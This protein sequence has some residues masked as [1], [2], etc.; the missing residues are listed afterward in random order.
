M[1]LDY[2][3]LKR[4]S[5]DIC[6]LNKQLSDTCQAINKE[7]ANIAN[8][9]DLLRSD[10]MQSSRCAENQQYNQMAKELE[11]SQL[12]IKELKD[13]EQANSHEKE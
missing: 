2:E 5:K 6:A 13:K 4:K 11:K 1:L 12:T 8:E 7:K 9:N 3:K 10:L